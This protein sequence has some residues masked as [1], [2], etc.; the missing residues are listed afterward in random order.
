MRHCKSKAS[1]VGAVWAEGSRVNVDNAFAIYVRA[2]V[3]LSP[4]NAKIISKLCITTVSW[5]LP[6]AYHSTFY[7]LKRGVFVCVLK[8]LKREERN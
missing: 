1:W 5:T 4:E 2:S 3:F 7:T 8:Y 6:S